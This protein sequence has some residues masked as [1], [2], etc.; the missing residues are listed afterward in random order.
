MQ[1]LR[2]AQLDHRIRTSARRSLRRRKGRSVSEQDKG[3]SA[4]VRKRDRGEIIGQ[5]GMWLA[6]WSL[7]LA[8]ISL[9][10]WIFG[11]LI[12]KL[13]VIILPVALAI[14]VATVMWPPTRGMIKRGMPPAA[15]AGITLVLS[16]GILAGVIAGIVPSVVSQAPELANKTTEG[17]NQVQDWLQGPPLNLKDDQIDNAV[18]AVITKVQESGTAIASGVFSGVST[19]SSLLVTLGLV[20]I[21]AFFFIKDGPRFHPLAPRCRRRPR[22]SASRRGPHPHVGHARRIHQDTS[23]GESDRRGL[24]RRRIAD[25]RGPAGTGA[26]NSHVHRWLHPDRRCLCRRRPGRVGCA[27]GQRSHHR[28]HRVESSSWPFSRSKETSF[29]LCCRASR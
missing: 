16:I 5:G 20:L 22:R 14:V 25:T 21:L 4:G 23:T 15:A 6:K 26:G 18:H 28:H 13:W 1:S 11:W 3:T 10:A 8:S 9:G 7:V 24:H 27:G 29:S 17:I 12:E 2:S 19:A